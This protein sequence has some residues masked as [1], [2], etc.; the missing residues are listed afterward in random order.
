M[1]AFGVSCIVIGA[2]ICALA[3]L[4]GCS[5]ALRN[6]NGLIGNKASAPSCAVRTDYGWKFYDLRDPQCRR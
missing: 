3:F 4:A 5:T 2:C 1:K 6:G